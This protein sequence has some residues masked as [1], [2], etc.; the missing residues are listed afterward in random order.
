[1]LKGCKV[2]RLHVVN[3]VKRQGCKECGCKVVMLYELRLQGYKVDGV[4][5]PSRKFGSCKVVA[6]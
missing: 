5:L 6:K 4:T 1:M 3:T 2:E